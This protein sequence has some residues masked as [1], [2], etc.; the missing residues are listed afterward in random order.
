MI[1]IRFEIEKHHR[2]FLRPVIQQGKEYPLRDSNRL[3]QEADQIIASHHQ[4][5][6][7]IYNIQDDEG[8]ISFRADLTLGE[9][10][11]MNILLQVN[12]TLNTVFS[13]RS[14][15]EKKDLLNSLE[16]AFLEEPSTSPVA[17][18]KEKVE[19]KETV[20]ET[21]ALDTV[22]KIQK[23]S[24]HKKKK[25][26][27]EKQYQFHDQLKPL[28]GKIGSYKKTIILSCIGGFFLLAIVYFAWG[29]LSIPKE[30]AKKVEKPS[31]HKLLQS[32][33]MADVY[34]YYPKKWKD[35][36]V[37]WISDANVRMLKAMKEV[38]ASVQLDIDI[39]YYE[40]DYEQVTQ[41]YEKHKDQS[42]LKIEYAFIGFSYLTQNNVKQAEVL[43]LYAEDPDLKTY[44][45]DYKL[46]QSTLKET[47]EVLKRK[48]ISKDL[49]AE[50]EQKKVELK[51]HL[52]NYKE[53]KVEVSDRA[54]KS[55]V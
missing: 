35:T 36:R 20:S 41:L 14:Q 37:S 31:Y 45:S 6:S 4:R 49:R 38:N 53:G 1:K 23:R 17:E 26:T 19:D 27:K 9:G 33:N 16:Q 29:F 44:I 43:S 52:Q 12:Q 24:T 5:S 7:L 18:L 15:Q 13:D 42:Y 50:L 54:K 39:G 55:D 48:D 34:K 32:E 30:S 3:L 2:K 21:K 40:K 46:T 10:K 22:N 28:L 25:I 51:S 47:E 11:A 8:Q